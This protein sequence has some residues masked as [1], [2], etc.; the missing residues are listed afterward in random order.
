VR[1]QVLWRD[2]V[3]AAIATARMNKVIWS[4]LGIGI[5][6]SLSSDNFGDSPGDIMGDI[7]GDILTKYGASLRE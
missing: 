3:V 4:S 2:A 5:S 7:L 6:L 1:A